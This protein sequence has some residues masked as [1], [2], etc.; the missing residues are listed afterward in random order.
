MIEDIFLSKNAKQTET[1]DNNLSS[2]FGKTIKT[3]ISSFAAFVPKSAKNNLSLAIEQVKGPQSVK[4]SLY[5]K[6]GQS[7]ALTVDAF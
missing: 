2:S 3:F 4:S 5:C 7:T 6:A 1:E